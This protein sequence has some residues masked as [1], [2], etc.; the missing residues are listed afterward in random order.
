M[1]ACVQDPQSV[2]AGAW[3]AYREVV[4]G[5]DVAAM[6]VA[7]HVWNAAANDLGAVRGEYS[8]PQNPVM[9]EL[10]NRVCASAGCEWRF[11]QSGEIRP[12]ESVS[13]KLG[14]R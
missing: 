2:E 4:K 11:T 14:A 12:K 10:Y 7:W 13:Q 8:L 5:G 9:V 3:L 6:H 1:T